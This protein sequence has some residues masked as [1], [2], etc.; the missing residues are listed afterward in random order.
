MRP[1]VSGLGDPLSAFHVAE[2]AG[3]ASRL[4][5]ACMNAA[6]AGAGSL[7][8]GARLFVN[9]SPMT[10]LDGTVDPSELERQLLSSGSTPESV[11]IELTEHAEVDDLATLGDI[12][13]ALRGVGFGL[14]L[15]DAGAGNNSL[16]RIA[17]LRPDY[18][19]IDRSLVS[20]CDRDQALR[21]LV[22]VLASF[23]RMLGARV[24]AEGV[25]TLGELHAVSAAGADLAQGYVIA[26]PSWGCPPVAP[27][28]TA[29]IT[30]SSGAA[31]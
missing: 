26:R 10:L 27:A 6:L 7:T 11:V 21:Q 5:L 8:H 16:E 24:V 28:A 25:E 22:E 23:G 12:T 30:G 20:G 2:S 17:R 9:A 14:A 19:K 1:T 4:D 18:V 3:V 31:G 15:D 29:A 13:G